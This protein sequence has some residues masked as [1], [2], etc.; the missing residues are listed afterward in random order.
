MLLIIFLSRSKIFTSKFFAIPYPR[1]PAT[2]FNDKECRDTM[3]RHLRAFQLRSSA[4]LTYFPTSS[5]SPLG[6]CF[7]STHLSFLFHLSPHNMKRLYKEYFP[8]AHIPSICLWPFSF[9][10]RV[11]KRSIVSLQ[12]WIAFPFLRN[13]DTIF[14]YIKRDRKEENLFTQHTQ[15]RRTEDVRDKFK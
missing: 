9:L 3:L 13:V 1:S 11:L 15:T 12:L 7:I 10:P 6:I 4:S 14:F 2:S 5:L 8:V